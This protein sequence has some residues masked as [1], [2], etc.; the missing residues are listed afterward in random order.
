MTQTNEAILAERIRETTAQ[1]EEEREEKRAARAARL[2]HQAQVKKKAKIERITGLFLLL[3]TILIGV[4]IQVV[5]G[6]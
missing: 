6:Q 1:I 5:Y 4:L 3:A 2:K